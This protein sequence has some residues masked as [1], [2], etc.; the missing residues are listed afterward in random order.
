MF[1]NL[2]KNKKISLFILIGVGALVIIWF[3]Y[4]GITSLRQAG[5]GGSGYGQP[6]SV[7]PG[8]SGRSDSLDYQKSAGLTSSQPASTAASQL[9]ERKV[10]KNGSLSLLVKNAEQASKDIQSIAERWGG[11]VA[12][13]NIYEITKGTKAGSVTI[14]VPADK[15]NQTFEEIKKLAVKVERENINTQDITEQYIDLEAR[16]KNLKAEEEQYLEI[17][18]KAQEIQDILNVASRLS[19]VRGRIEQIEGQL[20]Y[21][22]QQVDLASVSVELTEEA[23]AEIWGIRWRPLY[24][25]KQAL[26]NLLNGL[27]GYAD[28]MIGFLFRLPVIL[29]WLATIALLIVVVWK[30]GYWVYRKFFSSPPSASV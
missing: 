20:K 25:V 4:S 26:R 17:M 28:A 8:I 1:S 2:S 16:L 15:F 27:T 22:A 18:K 24:V 9:T 19:E 14:R 29:L 6:E 3:V 23:D 5:L 7:S 30:I 10:I 13:A 21:L 12:S 11:F